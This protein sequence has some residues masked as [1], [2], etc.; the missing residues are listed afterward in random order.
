MS[1]FNSIRDLIPG[2]LEGMGKPLAST[3]RARPSAPTL[4]LPAEQLNAPGATPMPV[5]SRGAALADQLT[6]VFGAAIGAADVTIQSSTQAQVAANRS[7]IEAAVAA[8]G[9][10]R[11]RDE[12]DRAEKIREEGIAANAHVAIGEDLALWQE[13]IASDGIKPADGQSIEQAAESLLDSAVP[14]GA[15]PEWAKAYKDRG[16]KVVLRL[17]EQQKVAHDNKAKADLIGTQIEAAKGASTYDIAVAADAITRIDPRI[18]PEKAR[19]AVAIGAMEFAAKAGDQDLFKEATDAIPSGMLKT[20]QVEFKSLLDQTR[21]KQQGVAINAFQESMSALLNSPTATLTEL[22]QN[23]DGWKGR[24]PEEA[25]VK[26]T[27]T[28]A[29]RRKQ[30]YDDA[31]KKDKQLG[32]DFAKADILQKAMAELMGGTFAQ[33]KAKPDAFD[34][35]YKYAVTT[36]ENGNESFQTGKT[37]MPEAEVENLVVDRGLAMIEGQTRAALPPGTPDNDVKAAARPG[38]IRLVAPS[39]ILP[40]QFLGEITTG[41]GAATEWMQAEQ[42]GQQVP[43]AAVHA[44]GVARD[45]RQFAKPLYEQ[46]PERERKF[47]DLALAAQEMPEIGSGTPESDQ[48]AMNAAMKAVRDR[49]TGRT[50]PANSNDLIN[51]RPK[52]WRGSVN[53]GALI[54][55]AS[56][57]AT[58]Y[59]A[60]LGMSDKDAIAAA[61]KAMAGHVDGGHGV[62]INLGG[63]SIPKELQDNYALVAKATTQKWYDENKAYAE[64]QGIKLEHLVLSPMRTGDFAVMDTNSP[65]VQMVPRSGMFTATQLIDLLQKQ[66]EIVAKSP[67]AVKARTLQLQKD[68]TADT[69]APSQRL[70]IDGANTLDSTLPPSLRS[71]SPGARLLDRAVFGTTTP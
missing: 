65:L 35:E 66:P 50:I 60:I 27:D 61:Y 51:A 59:T 19:S 6:Q 28:I 70:M 25:R 71:K 15:S 36:D 2:S 52:E 30:I 5:T 54:S 64:S 16:R 26:Y 33:H 34:R 7:S 18:T 40:K 38:Q 41:I 57:L 43:P 45:L 48:R 44:L 42:P 24:V 62:L 22:Q 46:V 58:S 47:L 14:P 9:Q 21:A 39:G 20:E 23:L 68:R 10:D 17:F 3:S 69:L 32:E 63:I 37:S 1:Q 67:E 12:L 4:P 11:A 13:Q 31:V 53:E 29:A 8:K 49:S 55:R 56:Q